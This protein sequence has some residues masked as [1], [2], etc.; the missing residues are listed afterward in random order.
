VERK[1]PLKT[2]PLPNVS[3][4]IIAIT[5]RKTGGR[6]RSAAA[7]I[8]KFCDIEL[9]PDYLC[10]RVAKSRK[11]QAI[12]QDVQDYMLD[13]AE[14]HLIRSIIN[15][16]LRSAMFYLKNRAQSMGYGNGAYFDKREKELNEREKKLR[17]MEEAVQERE[18]FEDFLETITPEEVDKLYRKLFVN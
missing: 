17:A 3:D 15:G 11:L 6:L 18:K 1:G 16:D 8:K 10:R 14:Y 7:Y 5:L 4:D 12:K 13:L 9:T 2:E